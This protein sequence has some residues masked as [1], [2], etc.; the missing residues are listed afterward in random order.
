MKSLNDMSQDEKEIFFEVEKNLT[1]A[2]FRSQRALSSIRA[3][4]EIAYVS[5]RHYEPILKNKQV[6]EIH[7][8][9]T[10][11]QYKDFFKDQ[12]EAHKIF[13]NRDNLQVVHQGNVD[14]YIQYIEKSAI[15]FIFST[16]EELIKAFLK[17]LFD[18][19]QDLYVRFDSEKEIKVTL[20][21]LNDPDLMT[22]LS[23]EK[24]EKL[25]KTF[26]RIDRLSLINKLNCL[27]NISGAPHN[28]SSDNGIYVYDQNKF[29]FLDKL[30]QGIIHEGKN[31][32]PDYD[33]ISLIDYLSQST[34]HFFAAF[35]APF[36]FKI[37]PEL[38][39]NASI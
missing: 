24:A 29:E 30:R 20:Q 16:F 17:G 14:K 11:K 39:V 9:T 6:R 33:I 4:V 38:Y 2:L 37:D 18:F 23:K 8:F 3:N 19:N 12:R 36:G 13:M 5:F 27:F 28:L 21:N 22:I 25:K 15:V 7:N 31:V 35:I 34:W 1:I 26:N 32:P 10:N